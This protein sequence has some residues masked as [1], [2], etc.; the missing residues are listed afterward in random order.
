MPPSSGGIAAAEADAFHAEAAD[1]PPGSRLLPSEMPAAD[2]GALES[3]VY[4]QEVLPGDTQAE[5][6]QA[7][8]SLAEDA[9][10][11]VEAAHVDLGRAAAM[12]DLPPEAEV[13][14]DLVRE[15]AAIKDAASEAA[16]AVEHVA[17]EI[18]AGEQLNRKTAAGEEIAKETAVKEEIAKETAVMEE[19]AKET[20]VKEEIA[21]ETAVKEEIAKETAVKEEIAKEIAVMEEI[22][23]ETTTHNIG[24]EQHQTAAM[25]AKA[26]SVAANSQQHK[27]EKIG[28]A[29]AAESTL[30]HEREKQVSPYGAKQADHEQ[31]SLEQHG[32]LPEEADVY[33]LSRQKLR[34]ELS[35]SAAF[36]EAYETLEQLLHAECPAY[37]ARLA[38]EQQQQDPLEIPVW[39]G[40]LAKKSWI[41]VL[42]DGATSLFYQQQEH[43]ALV[44]GSFSP[45][46]AFFS[47]VAADFPATRLLTPTQPC[48][49]S[50]VPAS[51][52]CFAAA[53]GS[54]SSP[55]SG[56][57][58][59]VGKFSEGSAAACKQRE[60]V[61]G[62]FCLQRGKDC[63]GDS[64]HAQKHMSMSGSQAGAEMDLPEFISKSQQQGNGSSLAVAALDLF[65][66]VSPRLSAQA[67]TG[68]Q[69][70]QQQQLLQQQQQP[71]QQQLLQ[72]QQQPQQQQLLQ[73]QQQPQQQQLP[74]QQQQPQ[75]QQLPQQSPP[76]RISHESVVPPPP[77]AAEASDRFLETSHDSTPMRRSSLERHVSPLPLASSSRACVCVMLL[78]QPLEPQWKAATQ[79]LLEA[80]PLQQLRQMSRNKPGGSVQ[81]PPRTALPNGVPPPLAPKRTNSSSSPPISEASRT[82]PIA[83]ERTQRTPQS[84]G[85]KESFWFLGTPSGWWL[86]DGVLTAAFGSFSPLSVAQLSTAA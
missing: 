72:Q 14:E 56:R 37:A 76:L 1:V 15:T 68:Q 55:P 5:D 4:G 59:S 34:Q 6:T 12:E 69:Q 26:S 24:A 43:G 82:A 39:L 45:S 48:G 42:R 61:I 79:P 46:L 19:I 47:L 65:D 81:T 75:Q 40:A 78:L 11:S 8:D 86:Y 54:A 23:K 73:Q 22:A 18:L 2:A 28:Y 60:G 84:P 70:P 44:I 17:S 63:A 41:H 38:E 83:E 53:A 10:A 9:A 77:A 21:K 13:V 85:C 36:A 35:G 64:M 74:Q 52:S 29:E 51:P 16:A 80:V 25:P 58:S 71:Q 33:S 7:E 50:E 30:S 20:A 49:W 31:R 62:S 67:S 57:V 3:N 66:M 32:Y 27:Q